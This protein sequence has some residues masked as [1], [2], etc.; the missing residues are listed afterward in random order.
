MSKS[1][2][3]R[4]KSNLIP[5]LLGAVLLCGLIAPARGDAGSAR[6]ADRLAIERVYHSHRTGTK[7]P[8]EQV[9]SLELIAKQV[10]LEQH[11]EAVLSK[12]YGREITTAMVAEEVSRIESTTRAPTMLAELKAALGND[13]ARFAGAIAKPILVERELRLCFEN[14]DKLH[15]PRRRDAEQARSAMMA[16]QS[17]AGT[18]TETWLLA[19]RPDQGPQT[20]QPAP[21]PTLTTAK[22]DA[23]GV[24]ATARIAQTLTQAAGGNDSARYF[25]DIDPE[26]RNVLRVQLRKPGDVSAVI[27]MPGGFA[28][29][30]AIEK[31]AEHLRAASI[32]FPKTNYEEWLAQPQ[33]T[34]VPRP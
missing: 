24:E 2:P 29:F 34:A 19:P 1:P 12:V 15:S 26:L 28:V 20:P 10:R 6:C 4:M 11:K 32:T 13:P 27:E 22:S 14:D 8:F 18:T 23:Y 21:E 9:Q 17:V 31:T 3:P 25:D 5:M 33:Q 7:Q 30:Q 16:G